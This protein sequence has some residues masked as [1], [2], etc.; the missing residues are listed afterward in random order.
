MTVF[1]TLPTHGQIVPIYR[2]KSIKIPL[3]L[4][5]GETEVPKGNYNLEFAVNSTTRE[6]LL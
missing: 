5:Y 2:F 4:K 6:Y 1:L 3:D